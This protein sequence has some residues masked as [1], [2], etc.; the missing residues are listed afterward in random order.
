MADNATEQPDNR[1]DHITAGAAE[2]APPRAS[3]GGEST[4]AELKCEWL[5][6]EERAVV[7]KQ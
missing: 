6:M 1:P 4:T 2:D 5:A 3:L 7:L